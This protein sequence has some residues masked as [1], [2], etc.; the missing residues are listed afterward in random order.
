MEEAART[1]QSTID[2][3]GALHYETRPGAELWVSFGNNES[4]SDAMSQEF[5]YPFKLK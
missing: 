2:T 5:I 1:K 3:L 4:S